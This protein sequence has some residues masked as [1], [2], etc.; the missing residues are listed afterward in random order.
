MKKMI[1]ASAAT[2]IMM[3]SAPAF[4]ADTATDTF[5]INA[6]VAKTCTME[7]IADVD[8]GTIGVNTGA[9]PLALLLSGFTSGSTVAGYV[10]CNDTNSMTVTSGNGGKLVNPAGLPSGSDASFTNE[11]LYSVGANNY[12]NGGLLGP[13]FVGN[14][15]SGGFGPRGAIHKQVSFD[16]LVGPLLNLGKRPVAGT[17]SDTVTVSVTTS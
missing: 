5:D 2:A 1:L 10:S 8:L 12:Y 6:S 16:I 4:A 7:N 14:V 3:A 15:I 13:G 11:L 9:G 17:Y